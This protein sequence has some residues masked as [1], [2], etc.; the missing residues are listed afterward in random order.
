MDRE[1]PLLRGYQT[2]D[3]FHAQLPCIPQHTTSL[4]SNTPVIHS[5]FLLA[6]SNPLPASHL[7]LTSC[8]HLLPTSCL[9][10]LQ[11]HTYF[12]LCFAFLTFF[13]LFSR[14]FS[15]SLY[16]SATASP[17]FRFFSPVLTDTVRLSARP[18][19]DALATERS[20]SVQASAPAPI[21]YLW[22]K[23]VSTGIM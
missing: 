11:L 6:T 12:R 14:P 5:P 1:R 17:A 13:S 22:K 10:L 3:S 23:A 9:H 8:L 18:P 19:F 15:A 20:A 2:P 7:L 21:S 4:Q 16:A